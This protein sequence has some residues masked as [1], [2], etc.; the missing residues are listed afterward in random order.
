MFPLLKLNG[1]FSN[2]IK[3]IPAWKEFKY[4]K[5]MNAFLEVN[6]FGNLNSNKEKIFSWKNLYPKRIFTLNGEIFL[7]ILGNARKEKNHFL[8]PRE[9]KAFL[10][11][12]KESL[13]SG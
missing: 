10:T 8:L 9:L 5:D 1:N 13:T 4:N 7:L 12:R 11:P 3:L 6:F 2:E